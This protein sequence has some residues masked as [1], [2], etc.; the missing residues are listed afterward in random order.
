MSEQRVQATG[1]C[2]CDTNP[3]RYEYT[4]APFEVHYCLCTDCTDIS[5][6]AMALIAVV[7][8]DAFRITQGEEKIRNFDT[9]ETAHRRFCGDCGCHM[10]LYVDAF[11]EH[12][13]IHVPTLDRRSQVGGEPDRWVFTDSKHPLLSIPDDGLPRHAGWAPTPAAAS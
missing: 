13:L 10:L 11:P 5:G 12:L 9:K 4:K 6:W 7:E 1:G 3:V 2:R 8:R